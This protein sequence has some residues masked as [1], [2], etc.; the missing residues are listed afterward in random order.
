[1]FAPTKVF[2]RWHR[3]VNKDTRR[4]A[5]TSAVAASALPSLV[6]ARGHVID[7][8]PELPLVADNQ[9]QGISKTKDALTWLTAIGANQD[10]DKASTKKRRAGKGK[11]RNRRYRWGK[12]PLMVFTKNDGAWAGFRN[13]PGVEL[14]LVNQLNLFKLA[15][16]GH[17]GRFI[18]WSEAAFNGLKGLFGG[19]GKV[20]HDRK[21]RLP[22]TIM[23][24]TDVTRLLRGT[25]LSTVLKGKKFFVKQGRKHN[26]LKNRP[27]MRRLNPAW[28]QIL[29]SRM[30]GWT[31]GKGG[32]KAAAKPA[33]AKP[34]KAA[35]AKPAAAASKASPKAAGKKGKK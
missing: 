22:R 32:K 26:P 19:A 21:Y 15:P 28:K 31:K 2:R 4:Y 10:V 7:K 25:E 8:V 29:R 14:A 18:I 23:A 16:G 12:G 30:V 5:V 34:A 27:A 35:A 24:N 6:M 11:W 17:I 13:L 9:I 1:M 3:M 33:A 20:A